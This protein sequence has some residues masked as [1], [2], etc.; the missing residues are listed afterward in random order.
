[1]QT[2]TSTVKSKA[3]KDHAVITCR[4]AGPHKLP[5]PSN[6]RVKPVMFFSQRQ[7]MLS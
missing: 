7:D 6:Q 4:S 3:R 5:I 1:M 2:I